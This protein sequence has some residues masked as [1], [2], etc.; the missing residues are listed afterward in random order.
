MSRIPED[1]RL[2]LIRRYVDQSLQQLGTLYRKTGVAKVPDEIARPLTPEWEAH[3]VLNSMRLLAFIQAVL[4]G[5][6]DERQA[7]KRREEVVMRYIDC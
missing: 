5:A 3:F 6:G 2:S 1:E 7:L 4:E